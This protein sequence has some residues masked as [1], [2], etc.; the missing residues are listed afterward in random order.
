[1]DPLVF[2]SCDK[3]AREVRCRGGEVLKP[4]RGIDVVPKHNLAGGQVTVDDAFEGLPQEACRKSVSIRAR[5][6][7]VFA[8]S[9]KTISGVKSSMTIQITGGERDKSARK[10]HQQHHV[11]RMIIVTVIS[12]SHI[13]ITIDSLFFWSNIISTG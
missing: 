7:I 2:C 10:Y 1:V 6:R 13:I 4:H 12:R 9:E 11:T 3:D 8:G 5:A